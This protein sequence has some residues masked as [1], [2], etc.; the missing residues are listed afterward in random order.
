MLVYRFNTIPMKFW[1]E[2]EYVNWYGGINADFLRCDT[3]IVA[4]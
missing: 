2:A 4:G 3:G 1:H